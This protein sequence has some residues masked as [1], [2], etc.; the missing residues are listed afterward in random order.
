MRSQSRE[1]ALG[2]AMRSVSRYSE[3]GTKSDF[4]RIGARVR[5]E[6]LPLGSVSS[7]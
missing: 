6:R 4:F 3:E 7:G 1:R 5:V 2:T